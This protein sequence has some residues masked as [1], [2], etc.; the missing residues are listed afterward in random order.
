MDQT[1]APAA[2]S[3]DLT[4][5]QQLTALKVDAQQGL[6]VL[7]DLINQC[8]VFTVNTKNPHDAAIL[9][10]MRKVGQKISRCFAT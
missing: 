10:G 4:P 5:E 8:H 2:P 3:Q 7:F 1:A 6:R 9:E